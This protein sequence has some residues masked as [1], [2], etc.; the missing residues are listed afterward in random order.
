M[1]FYI[2]QNRSRVE[3]FMDFV[4]GPGSTITL[5][6]LRDGETVSDLMGGFG[7]YTELMPVFTGIRFKPFCCILTKVVDDMPIFA[8]VEQILVHE[9]NVMWFLG[10]EFQTLSFNSHYHA[11]QVAR[12]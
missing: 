11:W 10:T 1:A 7:V 8:K 3:H 2:A 5:S 6:E 12:A 9:G 4:T